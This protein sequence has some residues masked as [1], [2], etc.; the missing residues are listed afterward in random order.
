MTRAIFRK[1]G[2][3]ITSVIIEGHSGYAEEGSDIICAGL[4]AVVQ[5]ADIQLDMLDVNYAIESN[6]ETARISI[7]IRRDSYQSAQPTLWTLWQIIKQWQEDYSEY[8]SI[9]EVTS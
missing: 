7:E 2:D 3:I 4:S 8:I 5:F 9:L 6:E 1:H